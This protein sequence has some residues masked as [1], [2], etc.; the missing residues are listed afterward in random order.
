MGEIIAIREQN[1][2]LEFRI[3]FT[4]TGEQHQ[5]FIDKDKRDL[6]L[7]QDIR[8]I[9]PMAC[10][11]LRELSPDTAICSVHLSRPELCRQYSCFRILILDAQGKKIGRVMDASRYFSSLDEHLN[12][13]WHTKIAEVTLPDDSLWE[14]Y[15]DQ[16][17]T[18]AGYKVVR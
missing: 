2:P 9:R 1:G 17:F 5:V 3:W 15:V 14:E 13:I 11:F 8:K 10:P 16:V 18:R 7:A 6:F 4:P 12:E